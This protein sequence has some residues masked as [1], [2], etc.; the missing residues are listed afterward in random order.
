MEEAKHILLHALMI[1]LFVFVM[2]V[3]VDYINVLTRGKMSSAIKGSQGRQYLIASFLGATP[4]CLG[5]FL[6]VSF[7]IHG[8]LTFG[9]MVG[10]MIAT[11]GDEAFVMLALFPEKALLLFA[12]LFS[13]GI[14]FGWV[15]DKIASPLNIIPC[16]GCDLYEIHRGYEASLFDAD[17]VRENL[18][19]I[20][21]YRALILGTIV[22]VFII[23][24]SGVFA[25]LTWGW[26]QITFL[27]LLLITA[28]VIVTAP[29]H[30]LKEHIWTHI[31]TKHIWR[32]FLWS[33]FALLFIE[34]GLKY[35]NLENFVKDNLVWVLLIGALVG[36]IPDSGPHLVFVMMFAQGM[37]PFSVLLVSSFVQDGHG[38]LPLL[39]YTL[40]DSILIKLFNLFFALA[41]GGIIFYLGF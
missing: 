33:F 13:M 4:G 2:M 39:S 18:T 27:A 17:V 21:W 11:S 5:A 41:V 20:T 7:Y 28:Y 10:G 38:M 32:I 31:F 12:L 15:A 37:I 26:K 29:D 9:A 40:R 3:L 30:Y 6:N 1:T 35:W 36:I 22:A 19:R 8:L 16:E 23:V 25:P 34:L 14:F 24:I